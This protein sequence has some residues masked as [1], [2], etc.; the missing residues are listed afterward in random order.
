MPFAGAVSS[1][2]SRRRAALAPGPTRPHP[3]QL[4]VAAHEDAHVVL[5]VPPLSQGQVAAVPGEADACPEEG[6]NRRHGRG[7][8]VCKEEG[9]KAE[10]GGRAAHV[11]SFRDKDVLM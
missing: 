4:P 10:S 1:A 8:T 7:G 6:P 9:Q 5:A 11:D 2:H 3:Q